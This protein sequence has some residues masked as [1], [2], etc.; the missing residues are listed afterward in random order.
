M[1]FRTP[2][3][4]T[5]QWVGNLDP[6]LHRKLVGKKRP[7]GSY[8][9]GLTEPREPAVKT[10]PVTLAAFLADYAAKRADVKSSTATVYGHTRRC[11][12]EFFGADKPL[13]EVTPGGADDFARWLRKKCPAGRNWRKTPP[14]DDAASPS[15]SFVRQCVI[16]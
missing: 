13:A 14:G 1:Q 4:E 3:P 6:S 12:V 7:D 9:V 8:T 2:L 16:D 10:A 5:S 15:S 11:L